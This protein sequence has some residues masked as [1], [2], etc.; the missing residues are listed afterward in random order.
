MNN[1]RYKRAHAR[2][3]ALVLRHYN[4]VGALH[5]TRMSYFERNNAAAW[6]AA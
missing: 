3:S 4:L 5:H 6:L 1:F 2:A